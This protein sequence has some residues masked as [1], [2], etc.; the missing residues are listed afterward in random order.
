[1]KKN[2]AAIIS[3]VVITLVSV[4]VNAQ[5]KPAA[6]SADA[7]AEMAKKL[8][9]PIASLISL[10]FQ[11]NTDVGIGQYNGVKNTLNI[12]PVIPIALS[13]KLNVITRIIIPIVTQYN[14]TAPNTKQ[15]GLSNFLASAF[16]APSNTKNGVTWG[17]GPAFLLPT[18]TNDL[19]GTNRFAI[20]PTVVIL[21]QSNGWTY[22]ALA[23]QLWSGS[24][25]VEAY[26]INQ[27]FVQPF[28]TYNWKSGAGA[29]GSF[30]W[31]QAWTTNT[32]SIYFM[33]NISGVTKLGKQIV[34]LSVAPR[35]PVSVPNSS[36]PDFGVRAVL[37]LVFPKK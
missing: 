11:N 16:F 23:N 13:P 2:L 22:G 31:T 27:M 18:T 37:V 6:A 20:G 17:A 1:M 24:G 25:T 29:G 10:P 32:T 36:R 15:S 5:E 35:I 14:I 34:S 8:A 28:I 26:E 12:Q 21:K 3:F 9:N 7:A 33:P 30:E 19:V 4:K